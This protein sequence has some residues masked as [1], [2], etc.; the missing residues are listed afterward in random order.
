MATILFVGTYGTD[1]PTRASMPFHVAAGA[2][3]AGHVPQVVLMGDA[4]SLIKD[5]VARH[6]QGVG[7]PGLTQLV[8]TAR[9]HDVAIHV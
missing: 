9:E 2:I 1:D 4:T 6:I 8:Q 3:E 5:D 7:M